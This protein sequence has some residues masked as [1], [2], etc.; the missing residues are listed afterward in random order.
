MEEWIQHLVN[1]FSTTALFILLTGMFFVLGKG[2]DILVEEAVT[3]SVKWGVSK[4]FIGIT[5]VSIGTT[6]PEVSVSVYAAVRGHAELAMGNAVG[7]MICDMGLILGLALLIAR[8][9]FKRSDIHFHGWVLSVAAMLLVV[10]CLP[11]GNLRNTFLDGGVFPQWMGWI[12]LCLLVIYLSVS[13]RRAR[14]SG[15]EKVPVDVDHSSVPFVVLKLVAGIAMVLLSSR[16]LI[17]TVEEIAWRFRV[18]ESIIAATLVAFGTSLPEL[19]T[20]ITAAR[21]GH[22]ELAIGNVLGADILNALLVVGASASVTKGGLEVPPAFFRLYFPAML[23]LVLVFRVSTSLSKA[24]LARW[25]CIIFLGI[26]LIT[27]VAGYLIS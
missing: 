3:L 9:S 15:T 6:L 16:F 19:V 25:L 12:F 20:A 27:T 10:A 24:H 11:F 13:M 1:N 21:K 14:K 8:L 5:L 23:L 4:L 26:Y 22:G 17:P 7:S 18:P 2:A